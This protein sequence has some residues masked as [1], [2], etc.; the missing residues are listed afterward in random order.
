MNSAED[1]Y[2]LLLGRKGDGAGNLCARSLSGLND[3]LRC[4]IDDAVIVALESDSDFSLNCHGYASLND[5]R[6]ANSWKLTRVFQPVRFKK[7]ENNISG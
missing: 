7:P 4:L 6:A 3:L 2:D 5:W 1:G